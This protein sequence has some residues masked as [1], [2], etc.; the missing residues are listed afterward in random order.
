MIN[1]IG[2]KVQKHTTDHE[3]KL[4]KEL[5][6]VNHETKARMINEV[7]KDSMAY[8]KSTMNG[9]VNNMSLLPISTISMLTMTRM[10]KEEQEES[11]KIM[12]NINKQMSFTVAKSREMK[13]R[14]VEAT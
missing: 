14:L 8:E 5:Q 3:N 13:N 12:V 10:Y 1:I 7:I 6:E 4:N 2:S 9:V 11:G